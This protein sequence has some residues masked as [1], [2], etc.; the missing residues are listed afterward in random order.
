MVKYVRNS[1]GRVLKMCGI[2]ERYGMQIFMKKKT[3]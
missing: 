2:V 3:R 1:G